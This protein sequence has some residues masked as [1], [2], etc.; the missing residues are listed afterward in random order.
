MAQRKPLVNIGGRITEMGASDYV[1]GAGDV[2]NGTTR[3]EQGATREWV[4]SALTNSNG[5]ATFY[6]T[7]DGTGSG[8]ALFSSIFGVPQT[9]CIFA[10]AN[11]YDTP[12][13]VVE[14]I[15]ADRKT[16]V[17]RLV[18]GRVLLLLSATTEFAPNNITVGLLV[19]GLP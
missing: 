6:L 4:G 3:Y 15:S 2:Y 14:S 10:G 8:T 16:V 9:N 1:R 17:V 7:S 12:N 11:A 19:K 18:R 5:R 13:A